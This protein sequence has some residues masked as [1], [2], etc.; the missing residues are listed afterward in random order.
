MSVKLFIFFFFSMIQFI[1]IN[2]FLYR[3]KFNKQFVNF[4]VF[5]T[6]M[7]III[8]F[9]IFYNIMGDSFGDDLTS[10]ARW[11]RMASSC[12]L[13]TSPSPRD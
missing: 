11:F 9:L 1:G 5:N 10:Y 8:E 7:S 13:Y 3:E 4:I 2:V 6:V 12:L